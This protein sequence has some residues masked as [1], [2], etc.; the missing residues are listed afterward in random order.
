MNRTSELS[1]KGAGRQAPAGWSVKG[2]RG[3]G[4]T[5][6]AVGTTEQALGVW[7]GTRWSKVLKGQ[8]PGHGRARDVI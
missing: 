5:P 7:R 8:L 3:E 1:G 2:A 4:K 6:R